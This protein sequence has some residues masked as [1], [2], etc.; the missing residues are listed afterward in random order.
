VK[1]QSALGKG[2]TVTIRLPAFEATYEK[3]LDY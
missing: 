3:D 1:I 2:T